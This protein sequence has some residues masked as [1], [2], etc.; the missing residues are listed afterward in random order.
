MAYCVNCGVELEKSLEHCPLCGVEAIN[1]KEPYDPT[2]PKPYST[3]IVRMQARVERRFSALII[4]VV[5]ALAAVVC[6]MAN[7]VYQDALT[8]S[9]YVVASLALIWV[10]ALFPLIYTGMHP[11]AVVMLDICV[12][13]LYLYVINL[14]DSSA[15]WSIT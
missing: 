9:V 12:L 5:F 11:V 8:W 13:L 4:S 7:L 10:L 1:P 3:R 15:D 6:V 14:A 2:L